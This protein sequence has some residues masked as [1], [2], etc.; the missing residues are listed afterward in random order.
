LHIEIDPSVPAVVRGDATRLRQI[1]VNLLSN[2]VKFTERGSVT[3]HVSGRSLTRGSCEL[4][5]RVR[6]TGIGIPPDRLDRLLQQFSPVDPATTRR[7]GGTGLGLA[8]SKR[9][10]ELMGGRMWVESEAGAGSTFHFTI[11]VK[12]TAD[13]TTS[14]FV[15]PSRGVDRFDSN[16]ATRHP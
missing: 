9:L 4:S 7:F 12:Q 14:P 1:L 16:F 2:A 6:D 8:I 13:G 3:T 5:F 15:V 11:A 10:A